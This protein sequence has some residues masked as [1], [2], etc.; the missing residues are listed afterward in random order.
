[1]LKTIAIFICFF[2]P[3]FGDIDS[4]IEAIQHAPVEERF[5]LMNAFKKKI[6]QMK[7]TERIEAISQLQSITQ[8]TQHIENAIE[9]EIEQQGETYIERGNFE[10]NEQQED[11]HDD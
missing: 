9:N 3:L 2:I 11:D 5:K 7:E 8:S 4:Q 6:V 1:M 10:E